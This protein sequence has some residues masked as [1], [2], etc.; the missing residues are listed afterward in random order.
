MTDS[1]KLMHNLA[2]RSFGHK[3]RRPPHFSKTPSAMAM[4]SQ[5]GVWQY[6]SA[7]MLTSVSVQVICT[8]IYMHV[9][10]VGPPRW[11]K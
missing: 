7:M 11:M 2:T 10:D 6:R 5:A 4:T 3:Q 9:E 1:Q 8:D